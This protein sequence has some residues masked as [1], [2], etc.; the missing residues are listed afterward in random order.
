MDKAAISQGVCLALFA[1]VA[2]QAQSVAAGARAVVNNDTLPVYAAMSESAD[3]RTTLKRGDTV[4]IGLVLFGS[5]TTWCAISRVGETKRLGFAS[6]EFLEPDRGQAAAATT[7]P[8]PPPSKPKPVTIREI[9][10]AAITVREVPAVPP[11][12]PVVPE[13]APIAPPLA[14]APIVESALP[15][16][17]PAPATVPVPEP[18]AIRESDFVEALLDGSGLRSSLANYT[19]STHLLTF[20]DKGRLAEIELPSLERVL[21]EQFQ[22]AAF[23]AAIGGQLRENYSPERS[24]AIAGWLRSAATAKLASLESQTFGPKARD[25]LVAFA[26]GLGASPPTQPRLVLIHRIYDALRICDMEVEATIALVHTLAQAIGPVLPKEKRYSAAEL[27]RALGA[28][29]SRYRAL[30]KNARIVHY[31]FAYRTASDEELEQYVNFLESEN[32]RWLISL[33][34]KGFYDTTETISRNLKAE[35]PRKVKPKRRLPG[36]NTAKGLLP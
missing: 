3:V 20:L 25:D 4:I 9:P 28:V 5:E 7:A 22:P 23:Y 17:N 26:G 24:A 27:D 29:K 33:I 12:A 31:L 6:C 21:S 8:T 35:I 11:P 2:A 36:E 19:Q 16:P 32:G 10:Q 1:A 18:A 13:P 15:K 30:M 14:A 34:D